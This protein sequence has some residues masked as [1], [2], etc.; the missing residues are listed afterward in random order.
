MY[1][2]VFFFLS[3]FAYH[4]ISST[5]PDHFF[6]IT[7]YIKPQIT[8]VTLFYRKRERERKNNNIRTRGVSPDAENIFSLSL[9]LF[10]TTINKIAL[11][12]FEHSLVNIYTRAN[13]SDISINEPLTPTLSF[14]YLHS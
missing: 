2:Q 13:I 9:F 6:F 8:R 5:P 1:E 3:F 11:F 10:L 14:I 12:L 7:R 4:A